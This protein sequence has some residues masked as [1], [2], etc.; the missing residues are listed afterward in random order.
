MTV[1]AGASASSSA[2]VGSSIALSN[3]YQRAKRVWFVL[4]L[5]ADATAVQQ[6]LGLF[7][8]LM[9][10]I[11]P[12]FPAE[13]AASTFVVST[14]RDQNALADLTREMRS[15]KES[16]EAPGEDSPVGKQTEIALLTRALPAGGSLLTLDQ[17]AQQ[18]G[19]LMEIIKLAPAVTSTRAPTRPS[20]A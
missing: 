1:V 4:L 5:G 9:D 3:T 14:L 16:L 10:R 17:V 15:L 18:P 12:S 7:A 8:Q 13:G 19:R 11:C 2:I 20:A 6:E